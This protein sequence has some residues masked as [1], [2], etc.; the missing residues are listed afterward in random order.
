LGADAIATGH[1]SRVRRG[2]HGYEL[3]AGVDS[4]KDQSYFLHQLTQEQLSRTLFPIGN[5]EKPEVRRLAAQFEL[6]TANKK[7][8]QGI[9]FIG[10][11]DMGDFLATEI[12]RKEGPI[13]SVEGRAIGCHRGMTSYTIGQRHGF[14]VSGDQP[15]FVVGK[16]AETNTMIVAEG[17]NHP[18]LYSSTLVAGDAH[19]IYR[20]QTLPI[21]CVARIRYRQELQDCT[22]ESLDNGR[23]AVKFDRLQRAVSPG[24]FA[25]FYNKEVCLGGAVIESA[26]R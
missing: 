20:D 8:S 4:N 1:Y 11:V 23:I 6:P 19:W 14:G 12:P 13:V 10:K 17:E 15:Y 7:D 5:L 24:Q 21:R 3:L 2:D 16:Q 26:A 25:V 18:A 9:C 22:V